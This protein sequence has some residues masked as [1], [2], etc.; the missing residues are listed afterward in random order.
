MEKSN[1]NGSGFG[2]VSG[3]RIAQPL[4]PASKQIG[5]A[6]HVAG[7]VRVVREVVH[8]DRVVLEVEELRLVDLG[9]HDELPAVVADGS[10]NVGIGGEDRV[11][12][13]RCRVGEIGDKAPALVALG[14]GDARQ[15][16]Q[17][18]ED[19]EQ[20][21]HRVGPPAF[22]NS[23]AGDHQ[24]RPHRV[25]I[26]ILLAKEPVAADRQAMVAGKDDERAL[27]LAAR[28]QRIEDAADL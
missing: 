3:E 4:L 19:V 16:A 27:V 23:R 21:A 26:E 6:G 17:C 9:I 1:S 28:P 18:R 2:L 15:F 13:G 12:A 7:M 24:R 10:L 25:V 5:H 14:R 8:L 20:V 22:R 11:A